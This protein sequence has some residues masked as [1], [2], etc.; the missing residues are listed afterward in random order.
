MLVDSI[1]REAVETL[2]VEGRTVAAAEAVQ[3][4]AAVDLTAE[5]AG[6]FREEVACSGEAAGNCLA[7]VASSTVAV[8]ADSILEQLL[9]VLV[10]LESNW[11]AELPVLQ[12]FLLPSEMVLRPSLQQSKEQ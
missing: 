2:E 3:K 1:L 9:L 11:L 10:L 4:V 8:E 12:P 6:N 5:A 7:M